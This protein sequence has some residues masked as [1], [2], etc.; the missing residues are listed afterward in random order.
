MFGDQQL[1]SCPVHT[2]KHH[3]HVA[4]QLFYTTVMANDFI[5]YYN[6]ELKSWFLTQTTLSD[7]CK[8]MHSLKLK[9]NVL[10]E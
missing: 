8:G 7:H 1:W 2:C 10:N 3:L 4:L 5:S 6:T 9:V